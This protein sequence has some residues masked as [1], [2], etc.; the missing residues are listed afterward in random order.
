M[1]KV[2]QNPTERQS[3][4]RYFPVKQKMAPI[5]DEANKKFSDAIYRLKHDDKRTA[6]DIWTELRKAQNESGMGSALRC[7]SL[8]NELTRRG[9][10]KD[11][12]RG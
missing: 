2:T 10:I 8:L 5:L 9:Q 7:V 12:W 6:E 3:Q 11:D 1:V 4:N